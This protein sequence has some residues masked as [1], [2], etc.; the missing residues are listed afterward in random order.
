[1]LKSCLRPVLVPMATSAEAK[2]DPPLTEREFTS[3]SHSKD[4]SISPP[5]SFLSSFITGIRLWLFKATVS[6]ALR[7][8]RLY[9]RS[10]TAPT[11]TKYYDV[12][13]N[14]QCRVFMPSN[15]DVNSSTKLPLYINIYGGGFALCDPSVDDHFAHPFSQTHSILVASINYRKGPRYR[16]PV[17]VTDV[18]ALINAVISDPLLPIDHTR[19]CLGGFSAGGNL[20][21]SAALHPSLHHKLSALLPIYPV[22]DFSGKYKGAFRSDPRGN[23]DILQ[24]TGSWFSW[25]YIPHNADRRHPLLSPIYA[26]RS[27]F[28]TQKMFFVGAEYDYL[29]QEAHAMASKLAGR[30]TDGDESGKVVDVS[31]FKDEWNENGIKW[32]MFRGQQHGFTHTTKFGEEE[33]ERRKATE[34][35]YAEMGRWLKEDVWGVGKNSSS[36][37][38]ANGELVDL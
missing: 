34:E 9:N 4:P 7:L 20:T 18:V 36:Q 8:F 16:F 29:C 15:I 32:R 33:K 10:K 23:A 14:L 19:I 35:C 38:Q 6:V 22:V 21:L 17:A 13:P 37:P 2:C 27:A 3:P 5:V 12:R 26:P 24:R 30:G 11:F 1:M 28:A 25:A 31:N